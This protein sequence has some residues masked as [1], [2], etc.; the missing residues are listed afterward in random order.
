MHSLPR[1]LLLNLYCFLQRGEKVGDEELLPFRLPVLPLEEL[2]SLVSQVLTV[3]GVGMVVLVKTQAAIF[4]N[5][6]IIVHTGIE[7]CAGK[8]QETHPHLVDMRR[9]RPVMGRLFREDYSIELKVLELH[10][11][12]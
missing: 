2:P 11:C 10:F 12:C 6:S 9:E 7:D 4:F 5:K 8:I 1:I 3:L